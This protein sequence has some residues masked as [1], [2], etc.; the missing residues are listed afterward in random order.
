MKFT[1]YVVVMVLIIG[2]QISS[3]T[4]INVPGDQP[5][6]QGGIDVA[7]GGDTVLVASGLYIENINYGSSRIIV[8]SVEGADFTTIQAAD[9]N[10]S[11]VSIIS[12]V[13]KGT[14]LSGFTITGLEPEVTNE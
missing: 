13:Q 8:T 2:V 11:T 7:S 5:T 4:I 9:V 14:E 10:L 12:N 3:A 1:L 6:I